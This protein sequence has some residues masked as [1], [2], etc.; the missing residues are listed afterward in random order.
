MDSILKYIGQ[1]LLETVGEV[2]AVA[3]LAMLC[4]GSIILIMWFLRW[5]GVDV[6]PR[7]FVEVVERYVDG[8]MFMYIWLMVV[9][10]IVHFGLKL[11][12]SILYMLT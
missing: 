12:K 7:R 4:V 11:G 8:E 2:V 10:L 1:F 6:D 5:L 3:L 9:I